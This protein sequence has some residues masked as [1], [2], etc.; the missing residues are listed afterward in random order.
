MVVAKQQLL[1]GAEHAP[2]FVAGDVH[3]LDELAVRHSDAWHGHGHQR[4]WDRVG[5][6][7]DDL[8]DVVA[9]VYLVH[10]KG[11]TRLRVRD[12]LEHLAHDDLGQVHDRQVLDLEPQAGEN[13]SG[14]I[15][16]DP[17]EVDE[18]CKPFVADS[19]VLV[20][21]PPSPDCVGYFPVE[22]GRHLFH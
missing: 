18:I 21:T 17:V 9:E 19:H 2:G 6:P 13:G 3:V 11:V 16:R 15:G 14:V 8:L 10:P 5:G 20:P 7:G 12:L 1:G 4:A 22:R